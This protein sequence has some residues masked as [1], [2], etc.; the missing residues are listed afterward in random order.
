[1]GEQGLSLPLKESGRRPCGG[2]EAQPV[3]EASA[4][5]LVDKMK[6]MG[7]GTFGGDGGSSCGWHP[8]EGG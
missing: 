6:P 1:M 7:G 8:D 5:G 2:A 4:G 3:S